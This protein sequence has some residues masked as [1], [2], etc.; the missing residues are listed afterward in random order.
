[1]FL[2]L[3][4]ALVFILPVAIWY[5]MESSTRGAPRYELAPTASTELAQI[6]AAKDIETL[7][8]RASMLQQTLEFERRTRQEDSL[9][10]KQLGGVLGLLLLIAG[11]GFLVNAGFLVW[12]Q[13]RQPAPA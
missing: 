12:A 5:A 4:A 6:R 2:N 3:L 1:M 10:T 7:R 9:F 8:Q 11:A 13:R